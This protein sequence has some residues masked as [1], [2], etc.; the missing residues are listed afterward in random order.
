[1]LMCVAWEPKLPTGVFREPRRPGD[2]L[3]ATV[4]KVICGLRNGASD[5]FLDAK[6]L[7]AESRG[8]TYAAQMDDEARSISRL[9]ADR[10]GREGIDA[11]LA[12]RWPTYR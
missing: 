11:F 4:E 1:M 8:R 12:K 10:D 3:A 9:I 7:I 5:D 6:R 2:E